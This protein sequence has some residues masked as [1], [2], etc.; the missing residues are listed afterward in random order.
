MGAPQ[1]ASHYALPGPF[2]YPHHSG[3]AGKVVPRHD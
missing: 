1:R 2:W 3:S